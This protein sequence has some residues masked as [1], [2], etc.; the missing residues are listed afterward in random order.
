MYKVREERTV[1]NLPFNS[2][3]DTYIAVG[4]VTQH[5]HKIANV[6]IRNKFT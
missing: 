6:R 1:I 2:R 3:A 5:S 4:D